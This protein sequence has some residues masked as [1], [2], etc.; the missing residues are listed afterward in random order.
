M[1]DAV[2]NKNSHTLSEKPLTTI[3]R[4]EKYNKNG[5]LRPFFA[6]QQ[7]VQFTFY[8][9]NNPLP[10]FLF[11]IFTVLLGVYLFKNFIEKNRPD[12]FLF[13]ISYVAIYI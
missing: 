3:E 2:I 11:N 1:D 13:I 10:T 5:M 6:L 8:D 12:Y 4:V 7:F 9:F